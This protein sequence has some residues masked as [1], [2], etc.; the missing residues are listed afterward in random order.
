[1]SDKIKLLCWVQGDRLDHSFQVRINPSDSIADLK[2]AIRVE[3][4]S[5]QLIDPAS[6]QLWKV[7]ACRW[8]ESAH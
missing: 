6:L 5:F 8:L 3:K 2:K 1:M 4:P 7:G